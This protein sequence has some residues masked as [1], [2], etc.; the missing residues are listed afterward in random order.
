MKAID[1]MIKEH[2]NISRVLKVIRKL[3][4]NFMEELEYDL[5]DYERII[6]FI[7][8][9]A[10][11]HHH[12]KEED[13]LFKKLLDTPSDVDNSSVI[14]GMYI[15][16]D[17]GRLYKLNLK[18]A[19]T[20]YNEGNKEAKLDIIANAIA[21]EDLLKRHIEKENNALYVFAKKVLSQEDKDLIDKETL[22]LESEAEK[23]K[24]Q[25]KYLNLILELEDKYL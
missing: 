9:Y 16:H 7:T 6:D 20:S 8:N 14:T 2:E 25:E 15:E 3:T 4:Y 18:N 12:R 22:K 23:L 13:I 11:E 24:T 1:I 5:N 21:Y 10:D 19:L 17:Y